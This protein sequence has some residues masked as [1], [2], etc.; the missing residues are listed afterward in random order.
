V[1]VGIMGVDLEHQRSTSSALKREQPYEEARY[2]PYTV[3]AAR[4]RGTQRSA[5]G[6]KEITF[7]HV[8]E[9]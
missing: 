4:A 1:G 6:S 9:K 5:C 8:N 2:S 3:N 7:R